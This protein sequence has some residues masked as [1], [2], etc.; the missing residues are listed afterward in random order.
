MSFWQT[1]LGTKV[2]CCV[3]GQPVREMKRHLRNG[4]YCSDLC[5]K[6]M[7]RLSSPDLTVP[8][9]EPMGN[10]GQGSPPNVH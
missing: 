1:I 4:P 9:Q 8:G 3:C 7:E 10:S 5:M 2:H 6:T